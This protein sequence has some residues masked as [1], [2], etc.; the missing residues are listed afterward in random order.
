MQTQQHSAQ[1]LSSRRHSFSSSASF[2]FPP[3]SFTDSDSHRTSQELLQTQIR[4]FPSQQHLLQSIFQQSSLPDSQFCSSKM[5]NIHSTINSTSRSASTTTKTIRNTTSHST[6]YSDNT[7]VPEPTSSL[8]DSEIPTNCPYDLT[9]SIDELLAPSKRPRNSKKP[10]PRPPNSWILFSKDY[11]ARLKLLSNGSG[12][13]AQKIVKNAKPEWDKLSDDAK[14][15]FNGLAEIAK[16]RHKAMYP[17]Y[18]FKPRPR[19]RRRSSMNPLGRPEFAYDPVDKSYVYVDDGS[20]NFEFA[21]D[22]TS[23]ETIVLPDDGR[24]TSV[25]NNSLIPLIPNFN[26]EYLRMNSESYNNPLFAPILYNENYGITSPSFGD[27][28]GGVYGN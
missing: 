8:S 7:S 21:G 20:N 25:Q 19:E 27:G 26:L 15:W 9:L 5:S 18:K 11:A 13:D 4:Q 1:S 22:N 28:N 6:I 16:R 3:N 14:K 10:P 24:G 23:L 2:S 12:A 17:E